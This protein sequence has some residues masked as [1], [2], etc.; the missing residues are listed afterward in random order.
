M[1]FLLDTNVVSELVSPQPDPGVA[2]WL[3]GVSTTL[4]Y[5][6]VITLG[7]LRTGIV[8]LPPSRRRA[9]L[10]E[11]LQREL[12]PTY[13]GRILPV[14]EAV[15][16]RWGQ[17]DGEAKRRGRP[18]PTADGLLA[19]TA[20]HFNLRLVTRDWKP[21]VGAGVAFLDPWTGD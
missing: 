21:L 2:A 4:S 8:H 1:A 15:A 14:D 9:A 17:L 11:W 19:A 16:D 20:L 7:E 6:S 18:L 5:L 10:E 13:A 12:L 3:A